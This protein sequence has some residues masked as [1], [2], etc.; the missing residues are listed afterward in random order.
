MA[1]KRQIRARISAKSSP[2]IATSAIW[3]TVL[4][5]WLTALAPILMSLSCTLESDQWDIFAGR[6]MRRRKLPRLYARTK[7]ASLTWL[8]EKREHDSLVQVREVA[9]VRWT[10]FRAP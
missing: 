5:E 9:G 1:A 6:A 4:R 8:E 7:R 3:N 10:A 2:G